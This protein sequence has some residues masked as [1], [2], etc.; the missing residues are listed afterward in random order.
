M[1]RLQIR[2]AGLAMARRLQECSSG[3]LHS[4]AALLV[5]S[6]V[7]VAGMGLS[8]ECCLRGAQCLHHSH[9]P[10]YVFVDD[11]LLS[12]LLGLQARA[13]DAVL[14]EVN[15]RFGKGSIMKLGSTPTKVYAP[16]RLSSA[17]L[18]LS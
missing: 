3:F 1:L 7:F 16:F 13:L 15:L 11:M 8:K 18:K 14:K 4:R 6:G 12:L 5:S 10:L 2:H 17:R 9:V